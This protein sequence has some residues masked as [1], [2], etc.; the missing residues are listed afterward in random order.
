MCI[1][2]IERNATIKYAL[3]FL[4]L[5]KKCLNYGS[6]V[7]GSEGIIRTYVWERG[8]ELYQLAFPSR[9]VFVFV[10]SHSAYV[11]GE[12]LQKIS[13]AEECLPRYV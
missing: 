1:L 8:S 11:F 12:L 10:L 5:I 9:S 2:F 3:I 7:D 4:F 6:D 13:K